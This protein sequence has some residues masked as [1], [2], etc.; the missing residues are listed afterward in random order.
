MNMVHISRVQFIGYALAL[1]MVMARGVWLIMAMLPAV[2]IPLLIAQLLLLDLDKV[3]LLSVTELDVW[4]GSA[5]TTIVE[6]SY[7]QIFRRSKNVGYW[8]RTRFTPD[9]NYVWNID[10]NINGNYNPYSY[11]FDLSPCIRLG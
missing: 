10:K 1:R 9:L 8:T 2:P 6:G 11:G 7:Y 3:K 5:T 4:Y